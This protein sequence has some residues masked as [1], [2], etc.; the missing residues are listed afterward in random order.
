MEKVTRTKRQRVLTDHRQLG[1]RL[2]PPI[3][4]AL[5]IEEV[6]W[7]DD[8]LPEIIWL[9]AL[10]DRHGWSKGA[11]LAVNLARAARTSMEA[12]G[13]RWFAFLSDF[14]LLY[15]AQQ[16]RVVDGLRSTEDHGALLEALEPIL[17]NYPGCPL[18]FLLDRTIGEDEAWAGLDRLR[19]LIATLFDKTSLSATQAQANAIYLGF[20][21][22]TFKVAPTIS[23][24][25]FPEIENYPHTEI[26]RQ[27]GSA[28]RAAMNIRAGEGG[29][30]ASAAWS[31]YFWNRGLELQPCETED[32]SD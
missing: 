6:K 4:E 16:A 19:T 21:S 22:G 15:G 24:A 8:I 27:I 23:L 2:I 31:R 29:S 18:G 12:P 9:A 13:A 11:A 5:P 25:R 28:V 3:V 7:V 20:T 14:S 10:N 17:S 26:S 32:E 1:R 30:A